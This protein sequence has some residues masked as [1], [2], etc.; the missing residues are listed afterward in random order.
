MAEGASSYFLEEIKRSQEELRHTMDELSK[1]IDEMVN[2]MVLVEKIKYE[3]KKESLEHLETKIKGMYEDIR[4]E[5]NKEF[6]EIQIIYDKAIF[7]TLDGLTQTIKANTKTVDI[8]KGDFK[9]ISDLYNNFM[10]DVKRANE[11]A[12]FSYYQRLIKIN[13]GEENILENFRSFVDHRKEILGLINALQHKLPMKENT[14]VYI[15]VWIAG[16][17]GNGGEEIKIYPVSEYMPPEEYPRMDKAYIEHIKPLSIFNFE[18]LLRNDE[19]IMAISREDRE[20]AI[21]NSVLPYFGRVLP[22]IEKLVGRFI[23]RD[24]KGK[25]VFI[26]AMK[27][28][29]SAPREVF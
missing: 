29:I 8:L 14:V 10:E 15:P 26:E 22:H 27:K 9:F 7:E 23:Y 13:I 4:T 11:A 1:K 5:E 17:V 19:G 3:S 18:D 6:N 24:Q 21:A 12:S 16:M 2:S 20:K 25:S 28:F